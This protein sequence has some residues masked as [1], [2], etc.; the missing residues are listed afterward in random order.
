MNIRLKSSTIKLGLGCAAIFA[1]FLVALIPN[2]FAGELNLEAKLCNGY[3]IV[4][5]TLE[6][7]GS[8][9]S[10]EERTLYFLYDTGAGGTFV[11]VDSLARVS[12]EGAPSESVEAGKR[13]KLGATRSGE[14][15]SK[16]L[17]ARAIQLDHLQNAFGSPLDGILAFD[18]FGKSLIQ[19]DYPNGRMMLMPGRLPRP[20]DQTIFSSK[21]PDNRPQD[22]RPWID[23]EIEGQSRKILIDSGSSN[24][25][26]LRQIETYETLQPPVDISLSAR[27]DRVER[28]Q[29]ARLATDIKI[30]QYVFE[31]PIVRDLQRTELLGQEVLK[32][33]VSTFDFRKKRVRLMPAVPDN[34]SIRLE[35]IKRSGLM[36]KPHVEGREIVEILPYGP[37]ANAGLLPG[38]IIT[39]YN[40]LTASQRG[41]RED[42][43]RSDVIA[44]TVLRDDKIV[45]T[46]IDIS[47]PLVD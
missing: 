11:D 32:Y 23:I 36:L 26:S 8:L 30:S 1:V 9:R 25:F 47:V 18:A 33:F 43:E 2:G 15:K 12:G 13:V 24:G 35:P 41:C 29:A 19:L 5:I 7:K 21:S 6:R 44:L 31:T 3:F 22:N 40:G 28:R 45:E 42:R 38:D 39:H 4:P 17:K 10:E 27:F 14:L 46:Q 16:S 34:K 20:D 37:S